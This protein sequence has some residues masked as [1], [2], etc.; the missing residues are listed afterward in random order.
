MTNNYSINDILHDFEGYLHRGLGKETILG[1]ISGKPKEIII[2][3]LRYNTWYPPNKMRTM[4][5]S[6][7]PQYLPTLETILLLK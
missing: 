4:L 1:N 6:Y 7:Y 3:M 2:L 5:S